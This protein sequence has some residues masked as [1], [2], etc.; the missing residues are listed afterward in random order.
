MTLLLSL[1]VSSIFFFCLLLFSFTVFFY[2]LFLFVTVNFLLFIFQIV[3]SSNQI[4]F[5]STLGLLS[6][7]SYIFSLLSITNFRLAFVLFNFQ[8][9]W[10]QPKVIF[11]SAVAL[12]KRPF[13]VTSYVY[14]QTFDVPGAVKVRSVLTPG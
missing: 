1:T 13:L 10:R 14:V 6:F 8:T 4:F 11:R 5:A 12:K 9:L 2:F 3:M 7:C